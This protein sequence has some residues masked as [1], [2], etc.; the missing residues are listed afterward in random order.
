MKTILFDHEVLA[1]LYGDCQDSLNEVF[2]EFLNGYEP[3]KQGLSSAFASGNLFTLKRLLHYYGPSYMYLG[4]PRMS[5][6]FKNLEQK[7]AQ[8]GNHFE[9]SAE[10][11]ELIRMV[12]KSYGEAI[13]QLSFLKKAV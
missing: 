9:L 13:S 11:A 6:M 8:A 2:S 12:E 7:C 1:N 4:M 10:F 5:E 3:M